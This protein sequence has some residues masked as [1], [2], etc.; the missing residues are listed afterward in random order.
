MSSIPTTDSQGTKVYIAPLG[1]DVSDADAVATAIGSAQ[2]IGCLQDIGEIGSTRNVTEY[3]CLSSDATT[4][5]LGSITLPNL[6][7]SLL[8]D[9]M[10]TTGQNELRNMY[11]TNSRRVFIVVLND[12][13]LTGTVKNATSITFD[14]GLSG[15]TTPIAKDTAVL[16]NTTVEIMSTPNRILASTDA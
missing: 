5:A 4:K 3:S 12:L 16:Y 7:F 11:D 2:A 10:D 9:A 6:P 14:G 13:P 1:T 8:F 15:E